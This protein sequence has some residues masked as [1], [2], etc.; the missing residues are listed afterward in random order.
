MKH[1]LESNCR[2]LETIKFLQTFS[3]IPFILT[4]KGG[5]LNN[6]PEV[7]KKAVHIAAELIWEK[8]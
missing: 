8:A 6:C 3:Q 1:P 5:V 4:F 7:V 2:N